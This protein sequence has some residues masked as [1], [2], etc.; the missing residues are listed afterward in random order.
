MAS[1]FWIQLATC[2]GIGK[3]KKFPGTAGSFVALL[4]LLAQPT[5]EFHLALIFL[6]FFLGVKAANS[7]ISMTGEMDP[8]EVVIDEVCGI[9]VTFFLVNINWITVAAGFVL[10]RFFDIVKPFPIRQFEQLPKGWGVMADDIAA[11][12]C[13]NAVLHSLSFFI[14]K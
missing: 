8:G 4:F 13:A 7:A 10:F 14:F 12:L 1:R 9:F 5:P 11:G 2:F 3:I 6:F